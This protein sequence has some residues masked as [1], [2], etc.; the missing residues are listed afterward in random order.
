MADRNTLA[1]RTRIATAL[2]EWLSAPGTL[3]AQRREYLDLL[4]RGQAVGIAAA[5][6]ESAAL[7]VHRMERHQV[8]VVIL[9]TE[10]DGKPVI[11]AMAVSQGVAAGRTLFDI[12]GGFTV[13]DWFERMQNATVEESFA[14]HGSE[15]TAAIS[16]MAPA[17]AMA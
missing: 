3:N 7:T 6:F 17:A 11:T 10:I 15:F 4:D 1:A 14:A 2:S 9:A 5:E 12:P 16:A 13:R 8:P